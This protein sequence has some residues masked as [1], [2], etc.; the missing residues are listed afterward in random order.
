[1]GQMAVGAMGE[2]RAR[3]VAGRGVR[4]CQGQRQ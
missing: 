3:E 1:M 4:T 2:N